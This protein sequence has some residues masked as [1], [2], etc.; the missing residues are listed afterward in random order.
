MTN[1]TGMPYRYMNITAS[2]I[3]DAD[4]TNATIRFGVNRSWILNESIEEDTIRLNRYND[5]CGN[6]TVLPTTRINRTGKNVSIYFEALT[7]GFSLFAITGERKATMTV[8]TPA[9]TEITEKNDEKVE[10]ASTWIAGTPTGTSTETST[11]SGV[12]DAIAWNNILIASLCIAII[13][14]GII[15]WRRKRRQGFSGF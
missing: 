1:V 8:T 15:F 2:N 12:Q 7:S 9:A 10:G 3:T 6:W 11:P 5:T 14:V 4:I 13:I